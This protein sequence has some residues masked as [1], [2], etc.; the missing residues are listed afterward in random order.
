MNQYEK[1]AGFGVPDFVTDDAFFKWI[2]YPDPASDDFWKTFLLLYPH[3]EAE[4]NEARSFIL[5]IG[6]ENAFSNTEKQELWEVI[7]QSSWRSKT[8][9]GKIAP[10]IGL[11]GTYGFFS[12]KLAAACI[13][14]LILVGSTAA[15]FYFFRGNTT[16]YA[17]YGEKKVITLPDGSQVTLNGNSSIRYAQQFS[18][19]PSREVWIQGEAFFDVKHNVSDKMNGHQATPFVVHTPGLNIEVLGTQ[20]NV[21]TRRG[22][23]GVSLNSGKIRVSF[24]DR[25]DTLTL[26]PGELVDYHRNTRQYSKK[27]IDPYDYSSWVDNKLV[28]DNTSFETIMH[29]LDDDYG[30]SIVLSDSSLLNEK[31]SGEIPT[32]HEDEMI[33]A[34]SRALNINITLQD[35]KTLV[36]S[37]AN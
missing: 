27:V 37:R 29:L 13:A 17:S 11:K 9:I 6:W 26:K 10:V 32:K 4:L 34:L 36:I 2:K 24:N 3:K 16:V 1:Y 18:D 8:G 30:Y 25:K 5:S 15:Y 14:G 35:K 7:K 23:A 28:L 20:F 31:L 12:R 33:R 19:K 22:D 21:N